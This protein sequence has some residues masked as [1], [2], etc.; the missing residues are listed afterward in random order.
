MG[1][2]GS[3]CHIRKITVTKG[4]KRNAQG[5]GQGLGTKWEMRRNQLEARSKMIRERRLFKDGFRILKR[6]REGWGLSQ[7]C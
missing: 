5:V 1:A 6:N 4:V 2:P 7:R 3:I